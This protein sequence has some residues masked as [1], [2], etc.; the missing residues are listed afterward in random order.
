[1][2]SL[3]SLGLQLARAAALCLVFSGVAFA[4]CGSGES[5]SYIELD[6]ASNEIYV[7]AYT[8]VFDDPINWDSCGDTINMHAHV[9]TSVSTGGGGSESNNCEIGC[10]ELELYLPVRQWGI[11]VTEQSDHSG[12]VELNNG[13]EPDYQYSATTQDSYDLPCPAQIRHRYGGAVQ[14][15]A[16]AADAAKT[17][18]REMHLHSY[19]VPRQTRCNYSRKLPIKES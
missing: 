15:Y 14:R 16:T 6:D 9:R 7:Y 8:Q 19:I 1:M 2:I 5:D 13:S 12:D 11:T 17:Y 4:Q 3:R 10:A 18:L